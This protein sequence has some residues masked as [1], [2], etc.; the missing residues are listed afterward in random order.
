MKEEE[1][2]T[3]LDKMSR[4]GYATHSENLLFCEIGCYAG[5][6]DEKNGD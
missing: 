1:E 4:L 5:L 2:E 6:A 3:N